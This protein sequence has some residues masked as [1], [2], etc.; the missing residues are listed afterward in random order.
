MDQAPLLELVRR[1]RELLDHPLLWT[2]SHLE[3]LGCHFDD[4]ETSTSSTSS[5]SSEDAALAENLARNLSP[6]GKL[7]SLS[8]ILLRT[9]GGFTLFRRGSY[10]F[11]QGRLIHRTL[12]HEFHRHETTYLASDMIGYIHYPSIN[13]AR[14]RHCAGRA[15]ASKV[16]GRYLELLDSAT[17]KDWTKDPIFLF[18]LLAMAQRQQRKSPKLARCVDYPLDHFINTEL[19]SPQTRLLATNVLDLELVLLCEAEINA[20][21]LDALRNLKTAAM[22]RTWPTIRRKMIPSKPYDTFAGRLMN[23]LLGTNPSDLFKHA[24]DTTSPGTKRR[25]KGGE[26]DEDNG[27]HKSRRISD[28]YNC[29]DS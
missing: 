22:P 12:F 27:P 8:K 17:P 20:D 13:G 28:T 21:V 4:L 14:W 9:K 15:R 6:E 11:L 25:Y 5:T 7:R 29:R 26:G 24:N 10:F 23:E 18:T 1:R 16:P 2:L 19:C 3:S